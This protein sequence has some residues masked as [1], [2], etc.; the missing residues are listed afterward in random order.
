MIRTVEQYLD[1]LNDGRVVYCLGEK[2]KDVRTHPTI[3]SVIRFA[4]M[5]YALPNDPRFR[6]LFVTQNEEGEEVNF[7][8][9]APKTSEDL[10]RR[11]DCFITGIRSGGGILLHCMGID[12]L[13]AVTVVA[14]R[15]DQKLGTGYAGRVEAYRKYLQ[16]TDL[17]I[18]GAITDVKGDR[19][20]HPSKQVQHKDFYLRVVDRNKEGIKVRGAKIHISAT[21][22]ANEALVLPCRAHGEEDK[23]YA[24]AFATPLKAKGITLLAVEPVTRTYGEEAKWDYPRANFLQP[25]ECM[26]VFDD[27][28]VPWE[29][30]FMCGEWQFSRDLAYAFASYHR[31]FG[32]C[33]MAGELEML[34][35]VAALMA[36]YNGLEK[37]EHIRNKLAWLAM[38]AET[39]NALGRMSCLES[40]QDPFSGIRV[41]NLM[42]TNM[43]KF[44]FAS[45]NHEACKIVQDICG[46]IAATVPTFKDWNNPEIQP[47]IE[48]YLGARAG[49]PTADRI[50]AI[51]LVKDMT[52]N[53]YQIDHIHG[54]G[55]MAAQQIF[56]YF[57]ADW[58]K[59]KA[60]ARR[61]A[62]IE[63]WQS[64]SVYGTL[65]DPEELVEPKMPP[66]DTSYRM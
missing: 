10:L 51:R 64:H 44:T 52:G 25:S 28:F 11:R 48:K 2:V 31:L 33:K 54:E 66:V 39:V 21:P 37:Y 43:A 34:T 23:D 5:D 57:S 13:A 6:P 8:F 3:R 24:L 49:V 9:T 12:A 59:F 65:P 55:S 27:V 45:H 58:A 40:T 4:A 53:Y 19:S 61:A 16:K 32:A 22:C 42:H 18:T 7:L 1:S 17:G 63:G 20:L 30:V 62:H 15:M 36:E 50:R 35:G 41:P 46:G 60:A 38:Y 56:L 29:K 47:Y 14:N 26:I